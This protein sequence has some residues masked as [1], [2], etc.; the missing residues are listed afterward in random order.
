MRCPA[1]ELAQEVR[2]VHRVY[3][4]ALENRKFLDHGQPV[5]FD[6]PKQPGSVVSALQL[7]KKLLVRRTNFAPAPDVLE[8]KLADGTTLRVPKADDKRG[9]DEALK[10][11]R[12][13]LG[14]RR[15]HRSGA[16]DASRS[17]GVAPE[18]SPRREPWVIGQG[19]ASRGA[20]TEWARPSCYKSSFLPPLRDSIQSARP[21]HGSRRGLLSAAAP[22]LHFV[23]LYHFGMKFGGMAG[24]ALAPSPFIG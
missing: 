8:V 3:A 17:N 5:L 20:A 1:P 18:S 10:R 16:S 11:G 22:Q 4:A 19:R 9:A 2:P 14:A 13:P 6:V 15:P 7:G 23:P 12:K 24:S 21:T